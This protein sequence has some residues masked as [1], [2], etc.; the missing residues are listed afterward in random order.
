MA[1]HP[2]APQRGQQGQRPAPPAGFTLLTLVLAA[3]TIFV[4]PAP[5]AEAATPAS[6]PFSSDGA[7]LA[8]T[9]PGWSLFAPLGAAKGSKTGLLL[10]GNKAFSFPAPKL[11]VGFCLCNFVSAQAN[12]PMG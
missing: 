7:A 1:T 8:V 11:K 3:A 9:T 4:A 12:K 6:S 10:V 2:T 5:V